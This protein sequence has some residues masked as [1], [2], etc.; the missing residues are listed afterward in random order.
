METFAVRERTL[1]QI[2]D[3]TAAKYPDND[4]VIY[5]DRDYRQTYREFAQ[6][7]DEL[8]MG[9]MA[10]GVQKGEK[11]AIWATNVPYWVALQFAT[12]K[13]GAVLLTVNTNYRESELRYLLQQ[14]ES[15]NLFIMDG[16][17]DHDYVQTIY[18]LIPELRKQQRGQLRC[19]HLPHLKRVMFLGVEKH[20]GMFSVP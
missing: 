18:T 7:V 9:L 2:L 14:S 15:E 6:L 20:R 13:I 16:Y 10:L 1:G 4:A 5:V 3:E 8:A 11:V 17:R 19:D 12:A